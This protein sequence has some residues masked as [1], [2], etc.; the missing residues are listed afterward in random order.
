MKWNKLIVTI[1][2]I[3]IISAIVIVTCLFINRSLTE[4]KSDYINEDNITSI[5]LILKGIVV[6]IGIL[7]F[8]IINKQI[9]IKDRSLVNLDEKLCSIED[10][11]TITAAGEYT[12]NGGLTINNERKQIINNLIQSIKKRDIN[13]VNDIFVNRLKW[14]KCGT[15][16]D[17][18]LF[19]SKI[20]G[21]LTDSISYK[22]E[23]N[24]T[25]A[26][27]IYEVV[28]NTTDNYYFDDNSIRI[29]SPNIEDNVDIVR[30]IRNKIKKNIDEY[31]YCIGFV[32]H[33]QNDIN[34]NGG[35]YIAFVQYKS[36]WFV[37]DDEKSQYYANSSGII[38]NNDFIK[39]YIDYNHI[40]IKSVIFGK[41]LKEYKNTGGLPNLGNTCYSNSALQLLL[42]T[43]LLDNDLL[44]TN[45]QERLE[46]LT[47]TEYITPTTKQKSFV[48][49]TVDDV[50][51]I[52][53]VT[54]PAVSTVNKEEIKIN[55]D[56]FICLVKSLTEDANS[57]I[58][59]VKLNDINYLSDSKSFLNYIKMTNNKDNLYYDNNNILRESIYFK[60]ILNSTVKNPETT[61]IVSKFLLNN[62]EN[63]V[64]EIIKNI[65]N[66]LLNKYKELIKLNNNKKLI[67]QFKSWILKVNNIHE[68]IKNNKQKIL[69]NAEDINENS[70]DDDN[71]LMRVYNELQQNTTN[72]FINSIKEDE[73]GQ[74]K[75]ILQLNDETNEKYNSDL[76]DF[77]IARTYSI[78][79][80]LKEFKSKNIVKKIRKVI[81]L[82][83]KEL[84]ENININNR[85]QIEK[86]DN[87]IN[88]IIQL[89]DNE[90]D[91][92]EYEEEEEDTY[93]QFNSYISN[94]KQ[95]NKRYGTD[96]TPFDEY[97]SN[98]INEDIRIK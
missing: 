52:T 43:D 20:V 33:L 79:E 44:A 87:Y 6:F 76:K 7:S 39:S 27:D 78:V 75:E 88:S 37:F 22:D 83:I 2:I 63:I 40:T 19:L 98:I 53:S 23:N 72:I 69:K 92:E 11:K 94:K 85:E 84:K 89:I 81:V 96:N 35:H 25:V 62:G 34:M 59:R 60:C 58:N 9:N 36:G 64:K 46:T 91:Y 8:N 4:D 57:M 66:N 80:V 47:G 42:A 86:I 71:Y 70:T 48:E 82:L 5:K 24:N 28:N 1:I 67:D 50:S 10:K 95:K 29:K 73:C 3:L 56:A 51:E 31:P 38:I 93:D 97:Y 21:T 54:K 45:I 30:F 41:K 90:F 15:Q 14:I 49:K 55:N 18:T 17:S 13:T 74:L 12:I 16:E 61:Q 68:N 77:L 26:R 32:V 65:E